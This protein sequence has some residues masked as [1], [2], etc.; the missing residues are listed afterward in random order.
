MLATKE[1][2]HL[3]PYPASAY[4]TMLDID[5]PEGNGARRVNQAQRWLADAGF[6]QRIPNGTHPPHMVILPLPVVA[7]WSGRWITL[8]L[9]SV[10]KRMDSRHVGSRA[11]VVHRACAN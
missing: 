5:D 7:D 2:H 6:I 11:H 3:R 4:A 1:P 10:V 9:G 8:P